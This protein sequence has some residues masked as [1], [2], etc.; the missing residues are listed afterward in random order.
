MALLPFSSHSQEESRRLKWP[1]NPQERQGETALHSLV[2]RKGRQ[3]AKCRLFTWSFWGL[4]LWG[5]PEMGTWL[6][7]STSV[8]DSKVCRELSD[9]IISPAI[10]LSFHDLHLQKKICLC[11]YKMQMS[12]KRLKQLWEKILNM[13][14]HFVCCESDQELTQVPREMVDSSSLQIFKSHL[15]R[16]WETCFRWHC[17]NGGGGLNGIQRLLPTSTI[18]WFQIFMKIVRSLERN[19]ED[20]ALTLF[21]GCA[22]YL[23][24]SFRQF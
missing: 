21:Q 23:G 12:L 2:A 10:N 5:D 7:W 14:K 4:G 20:V 6:L 9:L 17:L 13:Q 11:S 22:P 3:R 16:S 24:M 19:T 8:P 18:L 1:G 15:T